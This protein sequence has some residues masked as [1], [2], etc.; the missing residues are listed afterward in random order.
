[1]AENIAQKV[2]KEKNASIMLVEFGE[3][4]NK[5]KIYCGKFTS[6]PYLR[7]W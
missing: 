6:L 7:T 4:W 2:E 5:I 1:M 3:N